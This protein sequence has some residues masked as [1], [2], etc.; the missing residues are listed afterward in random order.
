MSDWSRDLRA[1]LTDLRLEPAR[2]AE[3]IEELSQ[4]LDDRCAEMRAAGTSDDEARRLALEELNEAGGL[5][6]RMHGLS[7][8]HVT[9]PIVPGRQGAGPLH[10]LWQDL[11]DAFRT[12]RRQPVFAST[13]VATLALGIAVNT[14]VFTIVNAAVLR[15]LPFDDPERLVR[16]GVTNVRNAEASSGR[17]SYLDLQD[18]QAAG[19]AFEHVAAVG[20]RRADLSG[21][22]Q[23][24]ARVEFAFMSWNLLAVLRQ[25]PALGRTFS[26]DDDMAGAAPVVI[27]GSD[28]WRTRY[29]ADPRILGRII[30]VDRVP[31]TV[32]GVMPPGFGFPDRVQLWL[33]LGALPPEE[34]ESRGARGLSGVGR[35]RAGV[36]N[37]QASAVLAGLT[38]S[39]AERYPD[40]NQDLVVRI[41]RAGIA[42][43]WIGV[44]LALVGAVGFVLLIACAN[45]S[46]LLLARAADR[47]RDVTLRLALGASRWR[48]VRHLLAES[49]LLA[50]VGGVLGLL[51]SY[52]GLQA[53]L[54]NLGPEAAPPSWVQF[55]VDRVVFAYFG[56]LCLGSALACGL[57]PAWHTARGN[58]VMRLND[59]GR[60]D[61]GGRHRRR[62]TGA[63]VVVQVALALVLLTGAMLMTRNLVDLLRQ[64]IGIDAGALTETGFSLSRREYTPEGRR[65]FLD[66]LEERFGSGAGVAAAL[67]SNAPMGGALLQR[68]H[69]DGRPESNAGTLP[70]VSLVQVGQ[71]YFDVLGAPLRAGRVLNAADGD[72]P[73]TVVV[74]ERFAEVYFQDEA[75]VGRRIRLLSPDLTAS[76]D[77][78]APWATIVGVIGNVRQRV[79]PSGEFD[80]VV[81]RARG[82]EPPQIVQVI[83]R[84][85]SGPGAVASFLRGEVQALDADLPLFPIMTI[86]DALS[87]QFWPQR[88]F[89][90]LFAVFAVI[91]MVLAA[92]GL[93]AVTAYAVSRRTQELGV[94][95]ALGAD[96][97]RVLWTV[98]GTTLRQLTIGLVL[99]TAGAA[100]V[101][102]VLPAILVGTDGARPLMLAA[103]AAVLVAVG[104][105][106]SA[107]P[108]RRALRLE[109]MAA[110]QAE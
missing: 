67:T 107:I 20:E 69:I 59:G 73:D 50:A 87:L 24:P 55:T 34:R 10:G 65:L 51:L 105:A 3:I 74:N 46:N 33:P 37:E 77:D 2:E 27:I 56:A 23:P 109:A 39:L 22:D 7:Q 99:G 5:A 15:P 44:M 66:R 25:P 93:Y 90:S 21:D 26:V 71:R 103:V 18:W 72:R 11:R 88:V 58:L 84:S 47:A 70:D 102:T 61:T 6:R 9:P 41:Q 79:L 43:E 48:I 45:V 106:A 108:A 28:L 97:R 42:P 94:R 31:T 4:H 29:G 14:T 110:L 91:A 62:W 16:L 80:P 63:F 38:S 60:G 92:C 100:A 40:T 76:G 83:V 30:R 35:L 95:M 82:D 89:G 57:V 13:I 104:V 85:P 12:I 8:T 36:T 52:V 19:Q 98:M 78:E 101:A 32:I 86:E 64:D 96:G 68:A 75:A 81:Y 54:A 49:V 53:F 17:L 1:R